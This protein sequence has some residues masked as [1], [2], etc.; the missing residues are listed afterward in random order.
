MIQPALDDSTPVPRYYTFA[1]GG[2]NAGWF[3]ITDDG[4]ELRMCATF[5]LDGERYDNPFAVRY[6]EDRVL[7][8]RVGAES[9]VENP[10][11]AR[12]YPS[13]AWPLLLARLDRHLVYDQVV[14]GSGEEVPG[15]ALARDGD[16]VVEC[17]GGA[18]RR[19]FWLRGDEVVRIDWGGPVSELKPGLSE[20]RAGSPFA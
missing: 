17:L 5:E 1:F 7:A 19:R 18:T 12:L 16:Q 20:A 15:V 11:P 3:E 13:A 8:W 6:V 10:A 2:D 9:W 4:I 14:E